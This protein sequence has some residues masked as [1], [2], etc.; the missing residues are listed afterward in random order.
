MLQ[1][2][3]CDIQH[4]SVRG[5]DSGDHSGAAIFVTEGAF[6]LNKVN[7]THNVVHQRGVIYLN[8]DG[9]RYGYGFMNNVLIADNISESWWGVA[10]HAKKPFA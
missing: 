1:L 3:E 9:D 7:I 2:T 10:I 8:V 6:R 4:F 5:T